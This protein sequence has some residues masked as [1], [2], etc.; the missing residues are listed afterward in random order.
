MKMVA[1]KIFKHLVCAGCHSSEVVLRLHEVGTSPLRAQNLDKGVANWPL[2]QRLD[3]IFLPDTRPSSEEWI[4][5]PKIREAAEV[6]ID[7]PE[8]AYAMRKAASCNPC[9]MD[10][11]ADDFAR[12]GD[13][14]QD[15]EVV[16]EIGQDA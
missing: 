12:G 7:G 6:A 15:V 11:R 14:H 16:G 5:G 8:F 13:L 10:K 3:N 4:S 9:I 2:R 1:V